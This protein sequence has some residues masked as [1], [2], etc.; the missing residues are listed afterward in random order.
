MVGKRAECRQTW[1]WEFLCLEPQAALAG[2]GLVL[3]SHWELST[4][5]QFSGLWPIMAAVSLLVWSFLILY[6]CTDFIEYVWLKSCISTLETSEKVLSI[7]WSVFCLFVCLFVCFSQSS[8]VKLAGSKML[9]E[10]ILHCLLLVC[11]GFPFLQ[12]LALVIH[13]LKLCPFLLGYKVC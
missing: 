12:N 10:V 6:F 5:P 8:A 3:M 13:V 4:Q 7:S 11:L 2:G 9:F 1:S